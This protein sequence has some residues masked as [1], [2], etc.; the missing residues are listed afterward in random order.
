MSFLYGWR[1][2][3]ACRF[4]VLKRPDEE[5]GIRSSD[6]RTPMSYKLLRQQLLSQ[7]Q[8]VVDQRIA[9]A[10]E[11]IRMAQESANEEGKSSAGD[12]YETGRAMAQLEIE[13]AGGQLADAKKLKQALEQIPVDVSGSI[14]RPG[15]LVITSQGSYFISIAAGKLTVD[16]KTWFA[17]SAGSP[18]GAILL[19]KREGDAVKMMGKEIVVERV[20]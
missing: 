14:V 17:I 8:M 11:T 2:I 19:G 4:I 7:C 13:K 5:S 18:L 12:K 10:E 15:S 6:I 9:S 3:L 1:A 20:G 16:G